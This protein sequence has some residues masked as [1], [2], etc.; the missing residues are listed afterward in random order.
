MNTLKKKSVSGKLCVHSNGMVEPEEVPVP[1][2][3]LKKRARLAGKEREK[4]TVTWVR[5]YYV[6]L[7]LYL[8]SSLNFLQSFDQ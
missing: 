3:R 6:L 1:P 2:P 5:S 7:I 4:R 8:N